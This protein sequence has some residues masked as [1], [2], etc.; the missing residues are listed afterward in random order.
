[1]KQEMIIGISVAV[2]VTVILAIHSWLHKLVKF[3]MDESAILNFFEDS[4]GDYTFR[5]ADTISSA[6]DISVE[7]VTIVCSNSKVMK[8]NPK[9]KESWCIE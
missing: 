7:R 9:E 6:T 2:T 3:K 4:E 5:S 8:R 1:M